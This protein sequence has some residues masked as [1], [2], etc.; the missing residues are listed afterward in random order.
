MSN[1]GYLG[2]EFITQGIE[3]ALFSN[4]ITML[5]MCLVVPAVISAVCNI[6]G[7]AM[8]LKWAK[9]GFYI[10][11]FAAIINVVLNFIYYPEIQNAYSSIGL[12]VDYSGVVGA[13]FSLFIL[14]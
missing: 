5:Y 11:S 13:C 8:L 6:W 14:C 1:L 9:K 4:S 7:Y 3:I 10:I 12:L 2:I